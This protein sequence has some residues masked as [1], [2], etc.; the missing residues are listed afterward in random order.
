M[1][2]KLPIPS[3]AELAMGFTKRPIKR[4]MGWRS[5]TQTAREIDKLTVVLGETSSEVISRAVRDLYEEQHRIIHRDLGA[6]DKCPW[7]DVVVKP[8]L[9]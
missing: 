1:A 6:N 5:S 2:E 7:C 9:N 4:Q 8:V 3:Q